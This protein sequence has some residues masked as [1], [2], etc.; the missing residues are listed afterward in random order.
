M[1]WPV[2]GERNRC[3]ISVSYSWLRGKF[4]SLSSV[5]LKVSFSTPGCYRHAGP[6]SFKTLPRRKKKKVTKLSSECT[7]KETKM[8]Y[9]LCTDVDWC[10]I[11]HRYNK[12]NQSTLFI[13]CHSW[14]F[15]GLVCKAL[16]IP[17]VIVTITFSNA[18]EGQRKQNN[19]QFAAASRCLAAH[20][21]AEG[22]TFWRQ[23]LIHKV[24]NVKLPAS[25]SKE[26]ST[27][28]KG[29]CAES[30]GGWGLSGK[31]QS[32]SHQ[33]FHNI[34]EVDFVPNLDLTFPMFS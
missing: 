26:L 22:Q 17:I 16:L 27:F 30:G 12:Q 18:A 21:D 2:C 20:Q 3:C 10:R 8:T 7:W 24:F 33:V 4:D 32:W 15:C 6:D 29:K 5:T 25:V 11:T 1:Q 13:L 14:V 34:N 28:Q 23:G 31:S 19:M 9:R